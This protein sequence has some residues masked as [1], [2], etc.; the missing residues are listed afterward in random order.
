M[1]SVE[2]KYPNDCLICYEPLYDNVFNG[3]SYKCK[4]KFHPECLQTYITSFEANKSV[5][6][7]PF[8]LEPYSWKLLS[9]DAEIQQKE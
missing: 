6:V 5:H 8:C 4:H 7:C 1:D 2:N 9:F 3:M